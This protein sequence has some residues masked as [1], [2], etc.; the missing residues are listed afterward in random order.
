VIAVDTNVL[1]Y[2]RRQET[3][4]H[5]RARDLV[6]KL[7]EG[8]EPWAVPWPCIYEFLRVVTHPRIFAPPTK[9][10]DAIEDLESL[11]ESP[12]ITLLGESPAHAGH[13]RRMVLEGRAAGN[14]AHDAH[15][16][17]LAIEHGVQELWTTDRDFTRFPGLRVRDPFADQVRESR[18]TYRTRAVRTGPAGKPAR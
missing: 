10:E 7:A 9:L 4:H 12:S 3:S 13:L 16:A 2:A 6:R 1:V 18:A 17:A 11:F 5:A 8:H 15:I 14:L